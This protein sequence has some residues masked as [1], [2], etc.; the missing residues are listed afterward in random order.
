MKLWIFQGNPDRFDVDQYLTKQRDIYWTVTRKR[1]QDSVAVGDLVYIWRA[2]GRRNETPGVVGRGRISA[3]CLPKSEIRDKSRLSDDLWTDVRLEPDEIKA[4]IHLE[5]VRL[6]IEEGMISLDEIRADAI[7]VKMNI[8]TVRTGTNFLLTLEQAQRLAVIWQAANEPSEEESSAGQ[9]YVTKEGRI[10]LAIH[11]IRERDRKLIEKVKQNFRSKH[12]S[13][14]CEICGFSFGA[15][16]GEIGQNF[17]EAHH[18]K[19]ISQ[20][21]EGEETSSEDIILVCSNCHRMLHIGDA[22]KN[23]SG[24]IALF[25]SR[26]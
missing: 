3:A 14:Y 11:R 16:Y 8:V 5:E 22:E 26:S 13:L 1:H 25:G 19:P 4:G 23:L 7:L 18:K 2:K 12:G 24:L 15:V 21:T 10:K 20:L 6:S 9:E 17:I